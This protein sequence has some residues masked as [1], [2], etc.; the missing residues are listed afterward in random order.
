MSQPDRST[1]LSHPYRGVAVAAL[2][3]ALWLALLTALLGARFEGTARWLAIPAAL[4]MTF[5]YTGLFITAHDAMHGSVCPA[6]RRLNDAVGRVAASAFALFAF[7]SL[8]AAHHEHHRSPASERDPDWHDGR[9]RGPIRWF[10]AFLRRYVRAPQIVGLAVIFNVLH[11]AVG[12]PLGNLLAFWVLPPLLASAQLFW[13]GTYLPLR[14]PPGGH[15][16]HH[17]A[18]SNDYPTL[19]SFLTCYHFGYHHE[20]HRFPWVPWWALPRVRRA[21]RE[22]ARGLASP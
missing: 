5:L 12:V 6:N 13:F 8:S 9:H 16:D 3:L 19:V 7:R 14:E 1:L 21:D 10:V 11:H 17:R 4:A 22:A 2:V 20:H 18:T 15:G